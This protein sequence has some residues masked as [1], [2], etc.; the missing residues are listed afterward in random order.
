M[1]GTY[2]SDAGQN[3]DGSSRGYAVD[4]D[5]IG[6]MTYSIAYVIPPET[7][8]DGVVVPFRDPNTVLSD[9][10][11]GG[12]PGSNVNDTFVTG[13]VGGGNNTVGKGFGL[14]DDNPSSITGGQNPDTVSS[15]PTDDFSDVEVV[16]S[17]ND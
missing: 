11:G 6:G 8:D 13:A 12:S 10:Q 1:P 16:I 3:P 17:S 9:T 7:Y 4:G 5:S 15:S 14:V 2:S